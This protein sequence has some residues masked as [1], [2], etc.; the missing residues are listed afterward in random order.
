MSLGLGCS[1]RRQALPLPHTMLASEGPL[2]GPSP[3]AG[4]GVGDLG[5][6]WAPLRRSQP[7]A[8]LHAGQNQVGTYSQLI[9][10][11]G[12]RRAVPPPRLG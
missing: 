8:P 1:L 2:P 6:I 12:S 11:L 7:S 5:W 4:V 9:R 3:L 10:D